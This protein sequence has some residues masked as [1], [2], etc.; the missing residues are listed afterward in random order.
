MT[1]NQLFKQVSSQI[2]SISQ[3]MIPLYGYDIENVCKDIKPKSTGTSLGNWDGTLA[4]KSKTA[5]T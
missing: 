2:N 5:S 1:A 3:Q 4:T